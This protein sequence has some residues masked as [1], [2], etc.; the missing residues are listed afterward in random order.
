VKEPAR[1]YL[2]QGQQPPTGDAKVFHGVTGMEAAVFVG[3]FAGY[4]F[5]VVWEHFVRFSP[6]VSDAAGY[7]RWSREWLDFNPRDVHHLPGYPI[8]LWLLRTISLG[9]LDNGPLLCLASASC[10]I[11]SLVATVRIMRRFFPAAR[12]LGALLFGLYPFVALGAVYDPR[13]DALAVLCIVGCVLSSLER[14][15]WLFGLFLAAGLITHKAIWLFLV[16]LA[17]DAVVHRK[18]PLYIVVLSLLPLT[19]YWACGLNHGRGWLWLIERNVSVELVSRSSLPIADG[20]V[21]TLLHQSKWHRLLKG[22]VV[23][24]MFALIVELLVWNIR[25]WRSPDFLLHLAMLLPVFVMM[26]ILNQYVIWGAIRFSQV[27][28]IPLACALASRPR[29]WH[30]YERRGVKVALFAALAISNLAYALFVIHAP[31]EWFVY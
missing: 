19:A 12:D 23:L 27:A 26:L 20:L 5:L 1:T 18:C 7:L 28:A 10:A 22:L 31:R 13:A 25:R 15:W 29:F 2:H 30:Y 3:V 24:A 17:V 6:V 21:G 14:K 4:L 11:A 16:I 8:L 9:W